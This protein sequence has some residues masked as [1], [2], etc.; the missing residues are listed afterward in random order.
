MAREVQEA[1]AATILRLQDAE[2]KTDELKGR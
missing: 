2:A 1:L